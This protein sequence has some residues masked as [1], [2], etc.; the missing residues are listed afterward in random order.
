MAVS[1]NT[2]FNG[3][4]LFTGSLFSS[5]LLSMARDDISFIVLLKNSSKILKISVYLN[6]L[7]K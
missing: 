5:V 4:V 6:E 7:I 2:N 1:W 3:I